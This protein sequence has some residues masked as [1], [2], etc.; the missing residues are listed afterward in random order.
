MKRLMITIVAIVGLLLVASLVHADDM[1][2]L[3]FHYRDCITKKIVNCE[4]IASMKNHKNSCMVQLVE[5]RSA[6]ARFYRKHREELVR[7]MVAHNIGRELH[8]KAGDGFRKEESSEIL[9]ILLV[10]MPKENTTRTDG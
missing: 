10:S 6:Q 9:E 2:Q 5:M 7:E 3:K 8:K 4:R 1:S